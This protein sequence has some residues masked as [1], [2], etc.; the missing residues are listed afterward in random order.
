MGTMFWGE[1]C[2]RG[3]TVGGWGVTVGDWGVTVGV[4]VTLVD[5]TM[6]PNTHSMLMISP[7]SLPPMTR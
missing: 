5:I 6:G 7:F 3:V 1:G 4:V 2:D